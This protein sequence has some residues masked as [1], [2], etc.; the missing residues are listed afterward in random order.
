MKYACGKRFFVIFLNPIKYS[1]HF[2]F[3]SAAKMYQT[4]LQE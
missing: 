2:V 4:C 1:G 3:S